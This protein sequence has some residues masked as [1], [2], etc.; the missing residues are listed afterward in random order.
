MKKKIW[1]RILFGAPTGLM[2]FMG[3]YLTLAHLRGD[4]EL[5][6]G[7][8]LLR[9]YGT[10]LNAMTA[11]CVSAMVIGMIWSAASVLFETDW[12]LLMQTI[13]H[14]VACVI[15]SMAIAWGMYWIPRNRDGLIQYGMLFGVIYVFVWLIQY[16]DRKNRVRQMNEMLKM[17]EYE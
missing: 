16:F 5:R 11:V 14:G 15:P 17:R 1:N 12:D 2:I 9:V 8:Y 7:Y 10:E 4:G 13:L 6:M 3:I